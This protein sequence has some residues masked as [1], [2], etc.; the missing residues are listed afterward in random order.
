[1]PKDTFFNLPEA[2]RELILE[3]ALSEFE[4]SS[5]EN[6]SINQIVAKAEISKGS[7]YQYFED[8]KDLY[9]YILSLIVQKKMEY[10]T[11]V[12]TNPFEHNFFTVIREMNLSGLRF[13]KENP[14]YTAIGSWMLKDMKKPFYRELINDNQGQAHDAYAMLLKNAMARKEVRGDIDVDFTARMIF[15]LSSEIIIDEIDFHEDHWDDKILVTLDKF[16]ALIE[17][18]IATPVNNSQKEE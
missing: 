17:N 10:I 16:M 4:K 9:K 7:F 6:V 18:G 11:P 14:R 3:I 8:K 12:M 2:K 5:Y 13:A 15:K 1:M